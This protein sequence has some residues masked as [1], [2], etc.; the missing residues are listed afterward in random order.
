MRDA[1]DD[2][3]ALHPHGRQVAVADAF[4]R[5]RAGRIRTHAVAH[6]P[7]ADARD[8]DRHLQ[9]RVE[10]RDLVHLAAADVHVVGERVRELGR[11]RADLPADAAEVVE[12]PSPVCRQLGEQRGQ[13]EDVRA[14]IIPRATNQS[15]SESADPN[16]APTMTSER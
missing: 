2:L 5:E 6:R 10:G 16:A 7:A 8:I 12:E 9:E 4:D 11:D 1:A 3:V 14:P 13:G 15:V